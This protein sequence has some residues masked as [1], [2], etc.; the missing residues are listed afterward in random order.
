MKHLYELATEMEELLEAEEVSEGA[1]QVVFGDIQKKSE[2]I[3]QFLA[4]LDA[5]VNTYKAEEERLANRRK[6]MENRGKQIKEYFKQNMQRLGIDK[7]NAGT[8][9][10][11]LQNSPSSLVVEDAENIPAEFIDIIPERKEVNK[12]RLKEALKN[13]QTIKGA[14]LNQDQHIRIR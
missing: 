1:L 9:K 4:V 3:C 2:N 8:F 6:A 11:A 7:I 5:E 14:F 12:T 13:G 10:V